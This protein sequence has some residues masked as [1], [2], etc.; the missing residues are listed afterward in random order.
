MG[1]RQ[2]PSPVGDPGH[3]PDGR[4]K[5]SPDDT[6]LLGLHAIWSEIDEPLPPKTR[7][8]RSRRAHRRARATWDVPAP[9]VIGISAAVGITLAIIIFLAT[10]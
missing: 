2:D 4:P 7:R 10:S 1:D 5:S 9:L 8:R 3:L 6:S